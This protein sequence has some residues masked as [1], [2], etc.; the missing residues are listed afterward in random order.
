MEAEISRID[1]KIYNTFAEVASS[2]GYSP[3]H[4]Q[5]IGALLLRG[6]SLSLQELAKET[7]Y[8]AGMV[9]LSLDLL[10]VLGVIKKVKKPGDR[11]LYVELSGDL[12]GALKK[13]ILSKVTKSVDS[14]MAEFSDAKE[15]L[16]GMDSDN[17]KKTLETI[18][19]LEKEIGR[20]K[21][22]MDLLSK[23]EMP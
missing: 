22:Y 21:S 7:G 23:A 1:R 20:L 8:S 11:R 2:I 19:T 4:G 18:G 6:R 10:E 3:I 5:L 15:K 9:S 12:L 14:F 13:A 16:S 17:A